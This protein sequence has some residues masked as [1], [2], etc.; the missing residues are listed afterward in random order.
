[1]SKVIEVIGETTPPEGCEPYQVRI[2][3]R[4]REPIEVVGGCTDFRLPIAEALELSALLR[5]AALSLGA[6]EPDT[7]PSQTEE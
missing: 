3:K 4:K 2:I 5:K 6:S 7:I 1:M